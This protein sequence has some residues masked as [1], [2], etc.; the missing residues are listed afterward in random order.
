MS[1][2]L[3]Q[4][5]RKVVADFCRQAP[6]RHPVISVGIVGLILVFIIWFIPL[7]QVPKAGL[8][9]KDWLH[10]IN[11]NRKTMAQIF[12]AGA[13]AL[14]GL[15]IA[16]V[17]SKA[18]RDQAEVDREQQLTDLYV[19]AIEQ[20]GSE[21]LQIRLGGIYALER[22]ARESPKDHWPIMEV[23]TA[24]VRENAP[25]REE[26]PATNVMEKETVASPDVSE[27]TILPP[28]TDI[29]AVLTVLGRTAIDYAQDGETRSLDL[30]STHLA[31]VDLEYAK[32]QRGFFSKANLFGADLSHA[33]LQGAFFWEANLQGARLVNAN[34]QGA[35]LDEANLYGAR[36]ELAN[37]QEV[38]LNGAKVQGARLVEANL[39]GASLEG[40][41]L[42]GANL[43]KANLFSA[44]LEGAYL[45][46]TVFKKTNLQGANLQFSDGLRT[47]NLAQAIWDE[48]TQWP[49]GFSPPAPSKK[50]DNEE[51]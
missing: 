32:L 29:Q 49:E 37:L 12:G 25:L 18:M 35:S 44:N 33:S 45:I 48:A 10:Q 16:W 19:K 14:V 5:V 38:S 51:E 1:Q 30:R 39:T 21:K 3:D 24:F 40:I 43:W 34:L 17:R 9:A 31:F 8:S 6:Q 22:I 47:N 11:E 23:L 15:Y 27:K 2:D 46:G 41:N 4:Q 42:Q 28:P 26:A 20:L 36:L 7:W 13:L 50:T